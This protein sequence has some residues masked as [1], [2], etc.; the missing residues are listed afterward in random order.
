MGHI[1]MS[2]YGATGNPALDFWRRLPWVLKLAVFA[3]VEVNVPLV[4]HIDGQKFVGQQFNTAAKHCHLW[5][6]LCM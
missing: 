6:H 5:V 1:H 3:F 2:Y 4:Q